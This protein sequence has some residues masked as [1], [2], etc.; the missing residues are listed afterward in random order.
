MPDHCHFCNV[1]ITDD[2]SRPTLP[3]PY[4]CPFCHTPVARAC[5]DCAWWL[6]GPRYNNVAI[7]EEMN[8]PADVAPLDENVTPCPMEKR[9]ADA[10][11]AGEMSLL[12]ELKTCC[13]TFSRQYGATSGSFDAGQPHAVQFQYRVDSFTSGFLGGGRRAMIYDNTSR[14]ESTASTNTWSVQVD[15]DG[16]WEAR[17]GHTGV[18]LGPGTVYDITVMIRPADRRYDLYVSDGNNTGVVLNSEFRSTST[19]VGR[20][21]A[22]S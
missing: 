12:Q 22:L 10:E 13:G 11:P 15:A 9:P 17:G 2:N 19:S 21:L 1:E 7:V 8:D 3:A 14:A 16:D 18:A 20:Y 5:N 6:F 4:T